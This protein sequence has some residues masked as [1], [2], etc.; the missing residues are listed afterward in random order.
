MTRFPIAK[1]SLPY[2]GGLAIPLV[3]FIALGWAV[4]IGLT[5]AAVLLVIN[6]FRDPERVVPPVPHA[7]VAPADGRIVFTGRVLEDRFLGKETLK[8]SIFMSIFDV[9]VNR[10]PVAGE[11]ERIHYQ[12]GKFF[13]ANLDKASENNE[14]N[15]VV[16]RLPGGEGIVFVQIAGLVARRIDCWVRAGTRVQRGERFGMI[17]FGSRVDLFVPVESH[18]AVSEGQRVKAGETIVC[19][20]PRNKRDE[21][22]NNHVR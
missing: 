16:L 10:V 12:Q 15:A 6:F 8:V 21:K 7:V 5:L 20:Y 1:E 17:R 3:I 18:L 19:Y 22:I 11:V 2:L 4:A 13:S 9:H 14:H